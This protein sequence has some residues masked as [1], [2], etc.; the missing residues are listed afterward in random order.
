MAG[1]RTS[2]T[3]NS[4][5]NRQY[6]DKR[7]YISAIQTHMLSI[8]EEL[9][10]LKKKLTE[11]KLAATNYEECKRQVEELAKQLAGLTFFRNKYAYNYIVHL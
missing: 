7:Y 1:F 10:N 4:D 2:D 8:S 9:A 6:H 5:I 3:A 11:N